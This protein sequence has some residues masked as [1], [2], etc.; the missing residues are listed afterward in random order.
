MEKRE[1][2]EKLL[3]LPHF[4][5]ERSTHA[6]NNIHSHV[7][8]R[9]RTAGLALDQSGDRSRCATEERGRTE[10]VH[11]SVVGPLIVRQQQGTWEAC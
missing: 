6:T 8:K 7:S 9:L 10:S 2:Y 3:E 5:A 1:R 4:A 11:G